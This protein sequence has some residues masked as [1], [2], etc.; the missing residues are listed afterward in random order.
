M[1]V[2]RL[3]AAAR[4]P[5]SNVQP[6]VALFDEIVSQE[7][8][9]E[10]AT[11]R[12]SGRAGIGN[13]LAKI[14][15]ATIAILVIGAGAAWA[16][17]GEN[18]V[19]TIFGGNAQVVESDYGLDSFSILQSATRQQLEDLPPDI[20]NLVNFMVATAEHVPDVGGSKPSTSE[21]SKKEPVGIS[22]IGEGQ[23]ST[24]TNA[25]LI[26]LDDQIC[27]VWAGGS[28]GCGSLDSIRE[29][30]VVNGSPESSNRRLWRLHGIVTDEVTSIKID[31]SNV[32]PIPVSDN[33]FE[34][35]NMPPKNL[36]LLGL[37]DEGNE[38]LV[39]GAPVAGWAHMGD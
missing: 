12:G 15:A 26:V 22:A 25:T 4:L 14:V 32:P 3:L 11:S 16:V 36:R 20:A 5:E 6:P 28:S 27:T 8:T 19:S 33:V 24:G 13:R 17:T 23:A 31:G 37:D 1:S 7:R 39:M 29:G 35:K 38:V 21:S 2:T 30:F 34:F 18:P 10:V 9:N